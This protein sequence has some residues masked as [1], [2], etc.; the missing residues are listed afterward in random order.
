[1]ELPKI[2]HRFD[3]FFDIEIDGW[4]YGVTHYPGEIHPALVHRVVKELTATFKSAIEH[5]YIFDVL[6]ISERFSR[7]AKY[8]I[9][10]KEIAFAIISYF[11][12]P[13]VFDEDAQFIMAQIIDKVEQA[14]GGAIERL[15]R[16]WYWESQKKNQ[17]AA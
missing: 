10:E 5:N 15:E 16:K 4:I 13:L 14:Y 11:P 6:G 17:K 7:A 12:S 8:L 9:H 3:E 1:M 2:K